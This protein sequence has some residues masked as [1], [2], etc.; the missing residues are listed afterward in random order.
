[1]KNTT[2]RDNVAMVSRFTD[3]RLI[4]TWKVIDYCDDGELCNGVTFN[5][6]CEIVYSE[7]TRR[8]LAV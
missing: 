3:D 4:V 6:W 5:E 7:L 2:Y 1:M 8:G